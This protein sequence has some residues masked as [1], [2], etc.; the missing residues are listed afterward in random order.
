MKCCAVAIVTEGKDGIFIL[1]LE[2]ILVIASIWVSWVKYIIK[3]VLFTSVLL[4]FFCRYH[5]YFSV[6]LQVPTKQLL[7]IAKIRNYS[8][9]N[10]HH[11]FCYLLYVLALFPYQGVSH[12]ITWH[13]ITINEYYMDNDIDVKIQRFP[14][15]LFKNGKKNRF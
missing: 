12:F 10:H 11:I 8:I 3:I 15:D 7:K 6:F 14:F 9:S 1:I 4:G 2:N 5:E 13:N